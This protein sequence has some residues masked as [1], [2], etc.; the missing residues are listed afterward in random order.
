M[1][2]S[3]RKTCVFQAAVREILAVV[4]FL[5]ACGSAPLSQGQTVGSGCGGGS[6]CVIPEARFVNV[7]W[8]QDLTTYD[9][10]V[11]SLGP[12]VPSFEAI[13]EYL[14]VLLHSTYTSGL[15]QY[16]VMSAVQ[17][18]PSFAGGSTCTPANRSVLDLFNNPSDVDKAIQCVLQA[19]PALT[20]GPAQLAINFVL[21]PK[22]GNSTADLT[23]CQAISQM[24]N[25]T[26]TARGWHNRTSQPYTVIP[27]GCE[28]SLEG[29]EVAMSHEIAE[30]L[31]D[32]VVGS[33]WTNSSNGN[34]IADECE[35][36]PDAIAKFLPEGMVSQYW[37]NSANVCVSSL[38]PNPPL[39]VS[40]T[41]C[42]SGPN[43]RITVNGSFPSFPS[44]DM[45][46]NTFSG[47]TPY[48]VVEIM[49]NPDGNGWGAG[50]PVSIPFNAAIPPVQFGFYQASSS[51]IV[52]NGFSSFYGTTVDGLL[53]TAPPG[54]VITTSVV[55][56]SSGA[57][58]QVS[59][60]V[61]YPQS[62][63]G[64]DVA[65]AEGYLIVNSA[66]N[67]IG[68]L[69]NDGCQFAAMPLNLVASQGAFPN[70]SPPNSTSITLTTN[71][72]GEF[73]TS[74]IAPSVA[75]TV[76]MS[77]ES[78]ASTL[79]LP[80]YPI[81]TSIQPAIGPVAGG[82]Q[83]TISGNGFASTS[84]SPV[85]VAFD[86]APKK[87]VN[88]VSLS[89]FNFQTPPSPLGGDGTGDVSVLVTVN[90]VQGMKELTYEYVVPFQPVLT[91]QQA[92]C[93]NGFLTATAFDLNG[94][95]IASADRNYEVI[96]TA[97]SK[98]IIGPNG[99]TKT[100]TIHSGQTIQVIAGGPFT[101]VGMTRSTLTG[102]WGMVA[103]AVTKTFPYLSSIWVCSTAEYG[104][105]IPGGN[106]WING[107]Y[108][109]F[110]AHAGQ[111]VGV[112]LPNH[113]CD[114]CGTVQHPFVWG[115]NL[116]V[117][118]TLAADA[119]VAKQIDVQ[120]LDD[121]TSREMMKEAP[122]LLT[123]RPAAIEFR[124]LV[125]QIADRGRLDGELPAGSRL[126]IPLK[127]VRLPPDS[128]L[129]LYHRIPAGKGYVWSKAG[130]THQRATSQVVWATVRDRGCY[131]VVEIHD[132]SGSQK[133]IL[134]DSG[135]TKHAPNHRKG[136]RATT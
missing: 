96:L 51:Q 93:A 91:F 103:A 115:S 135:A 46:S 92:G 119:A 61:P 106:A 38:T 136:S 2:R 75:Q 130:I 59:Q 69:T 65:T 81:V 4:F 62:V 20:M 102:A 122:V 95:A 112:V 49:S 90:G 107:I 34:E 63:V 98:W 18:T 113:G 17:Q 82:Q 8:E 71:A 89:T 104:P 54:S 14:A 79:S 108:A 134:R 21:P 48:I 55:D 66:A 58:S 47:Q 19:N 7:Y 117:T 43:M 70:S 84:A 132:I 27:T 40:E 94:D 28:F 68:M 73:S 50:L 16:G 105:G 120:V 35:N 13:D 36:T 53:Q 9:Q 121:A 22:T 109:T 78:T 39:A 76:T 57:P 86:G 56:P 99:K 67:V 26:G 24:F 33:G 131:A 88:P 37:S 118:F 110:G 100:I 42:G 111:A 97:P 52:I 60:S 72:L 1:R 30:L 126:G 44:W 31:T 41:V 64:F 25:V 101:A 77:A 45:T 133:Q 5:F 10:D 15:A 87:S 116:G 123:A 32:P 129:E 124:T 12:S 3:S 74:Y 11:A 125:V 23:D 29:A 85:L 83:A 80:V 114:F 6:S 128:H 127:G